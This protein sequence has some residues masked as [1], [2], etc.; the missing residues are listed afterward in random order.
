[1]NKEKKICSL[2]R[3]SRQSEYWNFIKSK[4]LAKIWPKRHFDN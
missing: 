3:F 2:L 4:K 1:M